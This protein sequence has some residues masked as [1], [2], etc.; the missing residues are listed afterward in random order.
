[1]S[2][3]REGFVSD[4]SLKFGEWVDAPGTKHKTGDTTS[5]QAV[6]AHRIL[7]SS[8][9]EE[10]REVGDELGPACSERNPLVDDVD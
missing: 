8:G 1:M 10:V 2:P 5:P 3:H 4:E 9:D 7:T 6:A